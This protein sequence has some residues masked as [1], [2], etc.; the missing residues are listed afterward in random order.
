[1]PGDYSTCEKIISKRSKKQDYWDDAAEDRLGRV[2]NPDSVGK[3]RTQLLRSV[4]LALR[5]LMRQQDT[6]TL[7][8]DLAAYIALALGEISQT[9][10]VSVT[11]WEKR[12]YW[13]K[14][15][16]FRMEWIWTER[17]GKAMRE[18]VL[19]DD[20]Q[21]AALTAAQ[22]A[23]KLKMTEVPQRHKLGTPWIGA[24]DRLVKTTGKL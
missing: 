16:R 9:I 20:W 5:E 19:H 12:G 7:T 22:V 11:A 3:E 2:I 1:M 6:N 13:L 23:E 4:V 21:S 17:L 18:A 15:D 8:R 14:A 24:W 10:D